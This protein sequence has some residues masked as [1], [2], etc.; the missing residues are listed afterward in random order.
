M[1][2]NIYQRKRDKMV[3]K[4]CC[5]IGRAV[6]NVK[7]NEPVV[8]FPELK[9]KSP[10]DGFGWGS[11]QVSFSAAPASFIL[12]VPSESSVSLGGCRCF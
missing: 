7:W 1:N 5:E 6:G 11:F 8:G 4:G 10:R 2:P 9:E 3:G 12:V